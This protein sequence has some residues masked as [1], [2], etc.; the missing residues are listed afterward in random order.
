MRNFL[1]S[2]FT[3]TKVFLPGVLLTILVVAY[4]LLGVFIEEEPLLMIRGGFDNLYVSISF[5]IISNIFTWLIVGY[6]FKYSRLFNRRFNYILVPIISTASIIFCLVAYYVIT[7]YYLTGL[8]IF[9]VDFLFSKDIEKSLATSILVLLNSSIF[10]SLFANLI[11]ILIARK[12]PATE[13][14]EQDNKKTTDKN[15]SDTSN[16]TFEDSIS[17]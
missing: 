4:N 3:L 6:I 15:V 17:I 12:K 13:K 9:E 1:K 16:G 8:F 11:L 10:I 7:F 5:F 14:K 2:L